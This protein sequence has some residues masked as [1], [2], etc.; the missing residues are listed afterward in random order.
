MFFLLQTLST[1][2]L[3]SAEIAAEG[4]RH[5]ANA[6]ERNQVRELT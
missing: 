2:D 5:L 4:I 6:L 3:S 1:L